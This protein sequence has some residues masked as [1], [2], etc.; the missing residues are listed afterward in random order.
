[1][2]KTFMKKAKKEKIMIDSVCPSC[3]INPVVLTMTSAT[4]HTLKL[5]KLRDGIEEDYGV[6]CGNCGAQLRMKIT[7]QST[8]AATA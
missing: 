1:M 2:K 4:K 8:N 3:G 5:S 6:S 7:A